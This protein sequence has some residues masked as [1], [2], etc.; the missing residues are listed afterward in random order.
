MRKLGNHLRCSMSLK[1]M[2]GAEA[3]TAPAY[4]LQNSLFGWLLF[5]GIKAI[6]QRQRTYCSFRQTCALSVILCIHASLVWAQIN[7]ATL[8]GTVTDPSG[9]NVPGATVVVEN[10]ASQVRRTT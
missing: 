8:G 1:P 3:T 6:H 5:S 10:A 9:G 2:N 4:R 7:T